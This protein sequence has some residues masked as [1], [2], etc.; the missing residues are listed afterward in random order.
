M[1]TRSGGVDT[2]GRGR[3]TLKWEGAAG[4]TCPGEGLRGTRNCGNGLVATEAPERERLVARER[5]TTGV[6]E[7]G[8][9]KL[10]A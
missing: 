3:K 2:E 10:R 7:G 8:G 6:G 5:D 1:V 9:V 4:A